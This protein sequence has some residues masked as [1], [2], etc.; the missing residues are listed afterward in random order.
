MRVTDITLPIL[1]GAAAVSAQG[2]DFSAI[3]SAQPELKN[4][5]PTP[6]S[7][8]DRQA[9]ASSVIK[10]MS[11]KYTGMST[12]PA[13]ASTD[14]PSTMTSVI[15]PTEAPTKKGKTSTK[16]A[17][18]STK[19][20]KKPKTTA[21]AKASGK[22]KKEKRQVIVSSGTTT[23]G[24]ACATQQIQYNYTP[25][26]NTPNG[27]LV[28]TSI[29]N[30][31]TGALAPAGYTTNFTGQYGSM[32]SNIYLGYSQLS[33]YSPAT[34]GAICDSVSSCKS[35]NLYFERDPTVNP[36]PGSCPNPTAAVSVRCALWGS[37]IVANQARNVGEWRTDFMVV[38]SGSN[39][40]AKN[41]APAAIS[42][43]TGPSAL[44]GLVNVNTLNGK[45]VVA[46]SGYY[47]GA[48]D[49]SQCSALCASTTNSN[50]AAAAAS[51]SSTYAACNYV[52]AAILSVGGVAQGT[53]CALYT[54]ADVS[55]YATL[56]TSKYN[57]VSYDITYSYG[58]ALNNVDSG[59]ISA[60]SGSGSG[61]TSSSSAAGSAS[62]GSAATGSTSRAS[63]GAASSTTI[64]S[65]T[66]TSA[67]TTTKS[68]VAATPSSQSCASLGGTTYSDLNGVSYQVRCATD[69]L[70]V[71]DIANM[72]VNAYSDCFTN[73]DVIK[74]CGGFAY[75][76]SSKTCF[77]KNLTGITNTPNSDSRV[78]LAW[79]PSVY[80]PPGSASSTTSASRTVSATAAVTTSAA[81]TSSP[82]YVQLIGNS[83]NAYNGTYLK[84]TQSSSGG[85][86]Y[87][88]I[89]LVTTKAAASTFQVDNTNNNLLL[90]SDNNQFGLT[91]P[92]S[93]SYPKS[94]L[95][96]YSSDLSYYAVPNCAWDQTNKKLTCTNDAGTNL[97]L[98]TCSGSS[99]TSGV[100][101]A[102]PIT[103]TNCVSWTLSASA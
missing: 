57:G 25:T 46:G 22:P 97:N 68:P 72:A 31:A 47:P 96:F 2:L 29:L 86:S 13:A 79:L 98:M 88:Y 28:D 89:S 80:T 102:S 49:P 24:A 5:Q 64:S 81:P 93:T 51:G 56:Y 50:K 85:Y 23:A 19:K 82:F 11:S 36:A 90:G 61:S 70:G 18:T 40:Y 21:K 65:T 76:A 6:T 60:G 43:Y 16:K 33:S 8:V 95:Y 94:I 99:D 83:G 63:T 58:Y 14:L 66:T 53:Y 91:I 77:F 45:S 55:S 1:A 74:G 67:T 27:F 39:G 84:S 71:G 10:E 48:Y 26:P 3:F 15:K 35:F 100:L 4:A 103:Q 42:G 92:Y 75:V 69:L 41:T 17:K 73:C 101:Y 59:V 37:Q 34:C 9:S 7:S 30:Q 54:T 62:T 38:I 20:G 87:Y 12:A 44:A 78:D 52:N 32:F